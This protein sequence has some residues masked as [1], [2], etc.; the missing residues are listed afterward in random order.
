MSF[1]DGFG[2]YKKPGVFSQ[3][4]SNRPDACPSR[5]TE[6]QR[7][8]AVLKYKKYNPSGNKGFRRIHIASSVETTCS[9]A[10]GLAER[11]SATLRIFFLRPFP[12]NKGRIG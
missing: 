9:A 4:C 7:F 6:N 3:I 8:C 10:C 5:G 2:F 1:V 12:H 11:G